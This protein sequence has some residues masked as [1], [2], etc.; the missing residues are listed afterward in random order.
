MRKNIGSDPP[1]K[2]KKKK[3]EKSNRNEKVFVKLTRL[4]WDFEYF[5]GI[6]YRGDFDITEPAE[7][8]M[9]DTKEKSLYGPQSPL[10]GTSYSDEQAFI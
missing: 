10:Y 5:Y 2:K 3:K 9:D 7:I 1:K 6:L 4:N 8:T